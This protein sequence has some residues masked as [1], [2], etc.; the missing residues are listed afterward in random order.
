M[1]N[2]AVGRTAKDSVASTAST[3]LRKAREMQRKASKGGKIRAGRLVFTSSS[4]YIECIFV[5]V[6]CWMER[7]RFNESFSHHFIAVFGFLPFLRDI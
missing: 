6:L 5:V 2:L 1:N 7:E 4:F 3:T